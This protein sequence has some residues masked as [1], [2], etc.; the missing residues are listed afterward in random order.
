MTEVQKGG[1][2][3]A[4]SNLTHSSCA[5]SPTQKSANIRRSTLSPVGHVI[6]AVGERVGACREDLRRDKQSGHLSSL[7]AAA[8]CAPQQCTH[9]TWQQQGIKEINLQETIA[10]VHTCRYLNTPSALASNTSAFSW[11]A[12]TWGYQAAAVEGRGRVDGRARC[13]PARHCCSRHNR[14]SG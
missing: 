13:L 2:P 4:R 10:R 6:G 14:R 8:P 3:G 7:P 5:E 12:F 9:G 1:A 11:M